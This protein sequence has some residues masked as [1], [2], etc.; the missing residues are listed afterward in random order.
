MG[1]S[2]LIVTTWAES[3]KNK[4]KNKTKNEKLSSVILFHSFLL[5]N[6]LTLSFPFHR[7]A[8]FRQGGD[9]APGTDENFHENIPCEYS[10]LRVVQ[11]METLLPAAIHLKVDRDNK[12]YYLTEES[13]KN[14]IA[15]KAKDK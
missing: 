5:K 13:A 4:N 2:T 8:R 3:K 9:G 6:L 14:G 12:F 11:S 7:M 15:P 10:N 1:Y